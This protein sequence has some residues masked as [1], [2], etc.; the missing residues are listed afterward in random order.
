MTS[1]PQP[2]STCW[3]L[4]D[5][6]AG[7]YRQAREEFT[8]L[9]FPVVRECLQARWSSLPRKNDID[10]AIQEV[11]VDCFR[12]GGALER[13]DRTK[14]SGFRGFLFGVIRFVALRFEE[15]RAREFDR[16][17]RNEPELDGIQG[18]EERFSAVFDREWA[19]CLV[20][21]A[22]A[23]FSERAHK[24]GEKAMRR[25][26]LLRMRF[27]EELPIREIAKLWAM[28][29]D[30]LHH[31]YAK[32]RNEYPQLLARGRSFPQ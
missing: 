12:P 13:A 9:Y 28:D 24:L 31:Q 11:F 14:G 29:P 22:E 26:E 27:E 20:N 16:R 7:G 23:K 25:R 8:R 2:Q 15:R 1:E 4:I 30:Y 3:T 18:D 6:A 19:R 17:T 21:E 5:A 10:D 32:A